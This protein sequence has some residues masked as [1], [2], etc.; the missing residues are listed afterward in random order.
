[1][2]RARFGS[3]ERPDLMVKD[4]E[5]GILCCSDNEQGNSRNCHFSWR[6]FSG[7]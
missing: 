2:F 1:M 5:N 7:P 6:D 3:Q 4:D